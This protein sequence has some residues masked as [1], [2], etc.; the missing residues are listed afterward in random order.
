MYKHL[1]IFT[2]IFL[3]SACQSV[4]RGGAVPLGSNEKIKLDVLN[5]DWNDWSLAIGDRRIEGSGFVITNWVNTSDDV[6]LRYGVLG[7]IASDL[8]NE[9]HM[10][11]SLEFDLKENFDLA[12]T[13]LNSLNSIQILKESVKSIHLNENLHKQVITLEPWCVIFTDEKS[14][15]FLPQ[16]KAVLKS[17]TGKVIWEGNY[18]PMNPSKPFILGNSMTHDDIKT[19]QTQLDVAYKEIANQLLANIQGKGSYVSKEESEKFTNDLLNSITIEID[20]SQ[21]N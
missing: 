7:V 2:F 1:F 17:K 4:Q 12:S 13:L 8:S 16:L 20:E 6:G 9:K 11:G 18:G 10:K 5:I 19:L 14:T 15:R 21:F 3:V